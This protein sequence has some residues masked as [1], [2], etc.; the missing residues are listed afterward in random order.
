MRDHPFVDRRSPAPARAR[1]AA[2]DTPTRKLPV[3][4]LFQMK[5][6]V[7]ASSRHASSTR[8]AARLRSSSPS[9]SS[10]RS[11]Q[12]VQRQRRSTVARRALRQQQRDRLREIADR[13]IALLEQPVGH[14][15]IPPSPTP[16]AA[17]PGSAASAGRREEVHGPRR[18]GGRRRRGST[19]TSPSTFALVLVVESI[20]EYR[21]ANCFTPAPPRRRRRRLLVV[22]ALPV[23]RDRDARR[24][25]LA[26][27]A[28]DLL[29]IAVRHPHVL[30]ARRFDRVPAAPASRR[31]R[32]A[33]SRDRA[34][35]VGARRAPASIRTRTRSTRRRTGA[36]TGSPPPTAARRSGCP[37]SSFPSA[38]SRRASSAA[39]PRR[40]RDSPR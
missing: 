33:R 2:R 20:A 4:S 9:G 5:R 8:R 24:A 36:A 26:Q 37:R 7:P 28:H 40:C 17:A 16:R 1:R 11:T 18:V 32:R 35:D 6:S 34:R 29:A 39:A 30:G 12:R 31:D 25:L 14:A 38:A 27:A 15:A 10:R 22:L 19:P 3:I 13:V 23:A 21:R